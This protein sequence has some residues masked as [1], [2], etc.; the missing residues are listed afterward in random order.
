MISSILTMANNALIYNYKPVSRAG[1]AAPPPGNVSYR[2]EQETRGTET[3]DFKEN[4]AAGRADRFSD[5]LATRLRETGLTGPDASSR[6]AQVTSQAREVV[7]QIRREEGAAEATR[8][9]AQILTTVTGENADVALSAVA[10]SRPAPSAGNQQAPADEIPEE[11]AERTPEDLKESVS[12]PSAEEI[13]R[14]AA[15][16]VADQAARSQAKATAGSETEGAASAVR[17]ALDEIEA[18]SPDVAKAGAERQFFSM[19]NKAEAQEAVSSGRASSY[20]PYGFQSEGSA[21]RAYQVAFAGRLNPG[22]LFSV[23]V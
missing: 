4:G 7:S 22:S 11:T 12:A 23:R 17:S 18:F 15:D 10:S 2:E 13:A 1:G 20:G 9:M 14:R 6:I 21:P 3:R 5:S 19:V 8:A 16:R